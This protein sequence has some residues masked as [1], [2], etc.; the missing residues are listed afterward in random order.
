MNRLSRVVIFVA[1]TLAF[2]A[3]IA[4]EEKAEQKLLTDQ[5]LEMLRANAR[6]D[7]A[8]LIKEY[9]QLN[10]TEAQAFW[11]IYDEYSAM[12]KVKIGDPRVSL[13]DE[14][15]KNRKTLSDKK[16]KELVEKSLKLQNERLELL[17]KYYK[18][19]VDAVGA[20]RALEWYQINQFVDQLWDVAI[21]A[22]VPLAREK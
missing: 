12:S 4:A 7:K 5:D 13:I 11:P 10:A 1:C 14:Y 19:L 8:N 20:K 21:S 22:Q 15:V 2:T 17:K 16:A 9:M 6:L 18:K 3:N